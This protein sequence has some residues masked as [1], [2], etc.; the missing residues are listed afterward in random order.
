MSFVN[1]LPKDSVARQAQRR[2]DVL[3]VVL[4]VA[5]MGGVVWAAYV[6]ARALQKTRHV[7]EQ[8]NQSYLDRGKHIEQMREL[9]AVK[10]RM[11]K[12][13]S[14]TAGLLERVPRSFLLAT[15]TKALPRGGSLKELELSTKRHQTL[16]VAKPTGGKSRFGRTAAQ[17]GVQAKSDSRMAVSMTVTGMATTDVE[18]GK[19]ISL[20]DRCPLID[21]VDLVYSQE[22]EF[23]KVLVREFEVVMHLKID[24]DVMGVPAEGQK[25]L[26]RADAGQRAGGGQ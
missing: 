14:L 18:V 25:A 6:S 13:A 9:E 1:L 10:Q 8:V 20:I 3:C 19:F 24:A 7:Y 21:Y 17:R 4:F 26:A 15:V 11:F 5:V 22:K 12:K 23:N 16:T 2:A